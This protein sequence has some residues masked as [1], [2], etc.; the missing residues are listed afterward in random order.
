MNYRKFYCFALICVVL[1]SCKPKYTDNETIL[2]AESLVNSVPDSAYYLLSS[3]KDPENLS[4]ADYAA[5]CL[6]YT[7]AQYKLYK[8]I[9][10]DSLI[11]FAINYY[12]K[13]DL[14]KYNGTAHYLSG[15]ISQM[16]LN[17]KKAM[18]AYKLA[19]DILGKTDEDNL[20]GLVDFKIGYIYLQDELFNESLAYYKKSLFYFKR[21]KN[22][23]YQ[24][25]TYRA[26]SDTY[27]RLNYSSKSIL[28]YND[29]AIKLSKES[30]DSKNYYDNLARKGELLYDQDYYHATEFLLQGFRHIPAQR[31][32]YAAFLAYTYSKL[33]RLDSAKYYLQISLTDT[34]DS[35][36]K[37]LIYLAGAYV[38]KAEKN[39]NRAFN[40]L[41]R[42]FMV[43]DSIFHESMRNQLVRIDKQY[44]ITKK[45]KENAVLKIANQRIVIL[46]TLFA[47]GFLVILIMLL[48]IKNKHKRKQAAFEMKNQKLEFDIKTEKNEN[49]Q[50]RRL[51]LAKL[52]N[53]IE[54]TLIFNQLKIGYLKKE[55]KED[56]INEITKQSVISEKERQFYIDEVDNLFYKKIKELKNRI[57]DLTSSDLIVISLMCLEIDITDCCSLL[58]MNI[59]T[60]YVRRKR[61]KK[62]IGLSK[63]DDL[64]CWIKE[65][66]SL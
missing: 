41:E 22:K 6:H 64:E 40:Y 37:I 24:A 4:K 42:A 20:K 12:G 30:G 33:N 60:M 65:N 3:I 35:R 58:D 18:L 5:W 32:Y 29:L 8:E 59:N 38:I 15:C 52:K 62:H 47:I 46:M 31:S 2:R 61:I 16:H 45:E 55:K 26:L 48:L 34:L 9:K 7:N 27:S 49:E 17:N 43:R 28:K 14:T 53:R 23:L 57:N 63:E 36:T 10:S 44:D 56:F 21:S 39:P 50:K 25:F 11:Q 66:I 51:L 19:E 54:N 13:S 1:A